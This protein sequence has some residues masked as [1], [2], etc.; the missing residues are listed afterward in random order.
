MNELKDLVL[1]PTT[2]RNLLQ[3]F[4]STNHALLVIGPAGSGKKSLLD[5]V[6]NRLG[7]TR[8]EQRTY[9]NDDGLSISISQARNIKSILSLRPL[10][11][12][13]LT[14][15]IENAEKL[16]T[17]AQN[18]LLKLL[19]EPPENIYFLLGTHDKSALLPT[20]LS[21]VNVVSLNRVSPDQIIDFFKSQNHEASK[22]KSSLGLSGGNIGLAQRLLNGEADDYK[23]VIADAKQ[24]LTSSMV[25]RLQLIDS[26]IKDKSKL[27]ETLSALERLLYAGFNGAREKRSNVE[28]WARKLQA[29][30]E[31]LDAL[32]N[33]VS[34][35]L[36]CVRLMLQL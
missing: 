5:A 28:A 24:I 10:E 21:R 27:G 34:A 17:E 8:P 33:N 29:V 9:I 14:V 3:F 31:S 11:G 22:I 26:L 6:A 15:I 23:T 35:R 2:K 18:A 25:D 19:E 7:A 16:T 30:E 12:S 13:V 36:V 1:H 20:V 4:D 32:T